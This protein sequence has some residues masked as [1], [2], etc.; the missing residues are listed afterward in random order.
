MKLLIE[1]ERLEELFSNFKIISKEHGM[2]FAKILYRRIAELQAYEKVQDLFN[3]NLGSPHFLKGDL[4]AYISISLIK[5][6]RII[7]DTSKISDDINEILESRKIFIKGVVD[8]HGSK[9]KWIII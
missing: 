8:Y 3:A 5:N 6:L 7:L 1:S 4:K 9:N 2:P